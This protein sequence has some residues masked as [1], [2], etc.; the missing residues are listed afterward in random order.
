[1]G[2]LEPTVTC[3]R[4]G[5]HFDPGVVAHYCRGTRRVQENRQLRIYI[6]SPYTAS[7]PD[8]V[9]ANVNIALDAGIRLIAKGHFP[10]IP[11]LAHFLEMRAQ[12]TTGGIDY[13]WYLEYDRSWLLECDA[14]L[15]LAP[16]PGANKEYA[17][18]QDAGLMIF[19]HEDEIPEAMKYEDR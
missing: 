4:C 16:S 1:M 14:L 13:H 8:E 7:T 6:A 15:F 10:F 2:Q 18:A 9:L 19:L 3:A 11:H 5:E 12:E 17:W